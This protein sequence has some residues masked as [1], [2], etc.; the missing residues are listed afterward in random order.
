MKT[1]TF[2]EWVLKN[3][4]FEYSPDDLVANQLNQM[5]DRVAGLL[6]NADDSAQK[7]LL[8]RFISDLQ[9]RFNENV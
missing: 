1:K 8:E 3:E 9:A 7:D 5:V 6:Y 4:N 2:K